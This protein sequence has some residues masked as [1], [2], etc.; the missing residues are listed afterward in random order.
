MLVFLRWLT[1][2]RGVRFFAEC[3][4]YRSWLP[5]P[6][7]FRQYRHFFQVAAKGEDGYMHFVLYRRLQSKWTDKRTFVVEVAG[8]A[9][10]HKVPPQV[11]VT[12]T[13]RKCQKCR[14]RRILQVAGCGFQPKVPPQVPVAGTSRKCQRCRYR[15]IVEVAGLEAAGSGFQFK[16]P[17]QVPV[18]GTSRKFQRCRL[19]RMFEV[20]GFE[21]AGKGLF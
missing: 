12:G 15:R 3:R 17:P 21:V 16:V 8:S 7:L 13:S 4:R 11:P 6:L 10:Q 14:Y 1:R 20:A 2:K 5:A 18:A 19:R 9:F